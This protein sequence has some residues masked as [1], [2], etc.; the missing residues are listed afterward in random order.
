[1]RIL[2][3][4]NSMATGGAEK[5]LL[6]TIPLYRQRGIEMDLLL[7]DGKD[8]QFLQAL[9]AQTDCKIIALGQ[10]SCYNPML[11]FKIIPQLKNYDIVHVHLF[12]ALYWAGLAKLIS[13]GKTKLVYTE[14]STDNK[15]RGN[16]LLQMVDRMVYA[17]Y[18]R[19][20]CISEKVK[21]ALQS[22][23]KSDGQKFSV[24]T[25]G[26]NLEK[27]NQAASYTNQEFPLAD[28]KNTLLIQVS[29]FIHPKDQA[30]I[31]R[32]LPLLPETVRLILI[33]EG[34]KL[35]ECRQLAEKLNVSGR[36]HFLGTRMDVPRLLKTCDIVLLSSQYEGVSLS[37]IE[38]LASG[39]PFVASDVPGLAEIV[40]GAGL[41]FP[42]QDE[43]EL[44][45]LISQLINDKAYCDSVASLGAERA[46]SYGIDIMIDRHIAL[47]QNL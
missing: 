4:I 39:R 7:L 13:L 3:I 40:S 6:E 41:L 20:I 29:S 32:A 1:M 30:T 5:L 18:D 46:K 25:N 17:Q 8:S 43:N 19:L 12:P 28:G 44:A 15:R 33:G 42:L 10:G 38:G 11:V 31:I 47:Y 37:S 36:V 35:E 23:L 24:I 45:R 9:R 16:F 34:Y 27:I 2:Q 26:V 21:N 22:H 14:H